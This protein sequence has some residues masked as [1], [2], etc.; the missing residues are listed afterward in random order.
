MARTKTITEAELKDITGKAFLLGVDWV[1]HT[2]MD[3]E[4]FGFTQQEADLFRK[5]AERVLGL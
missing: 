4:L 2:L 3:T 1:C 5:K